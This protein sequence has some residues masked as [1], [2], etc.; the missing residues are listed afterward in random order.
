M[1]DDENSDQ[2]SVSIYLISYI[3]HLFNIVLFPISTKILTYIYLLFMCDLIIIR[4]T[5]KLLS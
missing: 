1:E 5:I 2:E 3:N 4:I